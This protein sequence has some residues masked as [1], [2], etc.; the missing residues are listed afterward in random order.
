MWRRLEAHDKWSG[1]VD[2]RRKDGSLYPKWLN[3]TVVRDA[4]GGIANYVG[5]FLDITE[6]KENEERFI[7]LANHDSLTGLPNRHMLLDRL[8]G[9]IG[10]SQRTGQA[11]GLLFLDLD[12]FKWVNDSLGH[13]SGDKLLMAVPRA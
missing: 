1:E 6:R 12:N 13:A 10:L 9:A 11:I 2:D 7:H 8:H 3:I 5:T 4:A